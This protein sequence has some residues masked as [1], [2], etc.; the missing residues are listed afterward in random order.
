M[1]A[2]DDAHAQTALEELMR[3]NGFTEETRFY[4][5]T[6]PEFLSPTD[7]PG[8]FRI[9]ANPEPS[10]SVI[11]LYAGG[12]ISVAEQI[13]RG[14]AFVESAGNE[15]RSDDRA[16]VSIRL[17]DVLDQGGRIYP[18]QTVITEKTWY[19]TLPGGSVEVR[20]E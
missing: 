3:E 15:W 8:V 14:L 2:H 5:E 9:S 18:V 13:G 16:T 10:E 1:T 6:L 7:S 4:R 17:K 20:K 11:D 19:F 12:H